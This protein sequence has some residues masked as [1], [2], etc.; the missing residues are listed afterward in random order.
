MNAHRLR[1]IMKDHGVAGTLYVG[2]ILVAHHIWRKHRAQGPLAL[3]ASLAVLIW[4]VSVSARPLS[5]RTKIN[6]TDFIRSIPSPKPGVEPLIAASAQQP[7]ARNNSRPRFIVRLRDA[8]GRAYRVSIVAP[9][10]VVTTPDVGS[11][12][13]GNDKR[14]TGT[15]HVV[16]QRVGSTRRAVQHIS[17]F[18]DEQAESRGEFNLSYVD[19]YVVPRKRPREPDLLVVLQYACSNSQCGRIFFMQRGKLVPTVFREPNERPSVSYD[20]SSRFLRTGANRYTSSFTALGYTPMYQ[21]R[22]WRFRPGGRSFDLIEKSKGT[23][24]RP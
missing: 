4:L 20:E 7:T 11:G 24:D 1:A 22:I 3:G 19:V 8:A 10:E 17:L 14:A 18:G 5:H 15:Y 21:W 12:Y 2:A 6:P 23:I 16:L 13:S 9:D